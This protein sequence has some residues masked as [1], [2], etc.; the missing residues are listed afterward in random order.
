MNQLFEPLN[1]S[2]FIPSSFK[3]IVKNS[4]SFFNLRFKVGVVIFALILLF[5]V[6][7]PMVS[8]YTYDEINLENKNLP[9]SKEFIFGS[10]ELGRDVFTRFC[11]GARIS[12]SVGLIAAVI[13]LLVGV[14]YGAVAGYLGG[15][16]EEIMMRI[17][18]SLYAVPY[19]LYVILL[20]VIFNPGFTTILI[21]LT[22]TGWINMARIVRAE[23][24]KIK[25]QEFILAAITI[26][27]SK[28]RIIFNHLIPNVSSTVITTL[29]LS[30]SQAIFT[31]AFLSFLGLGI[32]A[33]VSSWGTM[34]C[35]GISALYYYPWRLF[36]PAMAITLTILACNLMGESLKSSFRII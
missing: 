10:D 36:F 8:G 22:I 13:D 25:N 33:P 27:A 3:P 20:T 17:C 15:K 35:D 30:V 12:L 14:I 5:A 31:E 2:D 4:Y 23:I 9:P 32:Q 19:L 28:K 16:T 1:K 18:D 24:L 7:G 11:Y 21:A 26:G 29:M 34:I 6:F